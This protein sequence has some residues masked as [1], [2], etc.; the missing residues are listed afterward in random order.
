MATFKVGDIVRIKKSHLM[1]IKRDWASK[2]LVVVAIRENGW[3][4]VAEAGS[5]LAA[6]WPPASLIKVR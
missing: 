4:S 6:P 5:R 1:S 3:V 2:E